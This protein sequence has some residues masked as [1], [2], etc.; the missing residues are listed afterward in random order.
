ML[1]PH[2]K[3]SQ[4]KSSR[5]SSN[6]SDEPCDYWLELL[7][8]HK[9][10]KYTKLNSTNLCYVFL[11][12]CYQQTILR[13]SLTYH[14]M[15]AWR[16][17]NYWIDSNCLFAAEALCIQFDTQLW[18]TS[19]FTYTILLHICI[20]TLH[21]YRLTRRGHAD[22]RRNAPFAR[23]TAVVWA[24]CDFACIE[25]ITIHITHSSSICFC[26]CV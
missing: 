25:H 14:H 26:I 16:C 8:L 10:Y 6:I 17:S 22:S 9:I 18:T 23:R 4:T 2:H 21:I 24:T 13:H 7:S 3:E 19:A 5:S 20:H 15:L 12:V 11:M 1:W